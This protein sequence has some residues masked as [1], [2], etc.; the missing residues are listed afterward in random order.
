MR[1]KFNI[2]KFVYTILVIFIITIFV[3]PVF[4]E[5]L[6]EF[7]K[8]RAKRKIEYM[9]PVIEKDG[10]YSLDHS[11]FSVEEWDDLYLRYSGFT[12]V[13][14]FLHYVDTHVDT[15]SEFV[16]VNNL[17]NN[18]ITFTL[19]TEGYGNVDVENNI[20]KYS[21]YYFLNTIN[22]APITREVT[23]LLVGNS[24]SASLT[25]GLY[26]YIEQY[27]DKEIFK[28]SVLQ[29]IISRSKVDMNEENEVMLQYVGL[30]G[31]FTYIDKDGGPYLNRQMY[32]LYIFSRSFT[33]YLIDEY[34]LDKYLELYYSEDINSQYESIYGKKLE[35][36][37]ELWIE[38][39]NKRYKEVYGV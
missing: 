32:A 37:R 33:R 29:D 17:G 18:I 10:W 2:D 24:S 13:S 14:E 28:K 26:F 31:D 35:E 6:K 23:E 20:I 3:L 39:V 9:Y 5:N 4:G 34:G 12:E 21:N 22:K 27:V 16:G 19:D 30:D 7:E 15:I 25:E 38:Y 36:L 8:Q 11:R 1:K